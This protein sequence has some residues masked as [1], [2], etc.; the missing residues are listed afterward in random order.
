MH[1]HKSG[2][3]RQHENK[4]AAG[5]EPVPKSLASA[6]LFIDHSATSHVDVYLGPRAKA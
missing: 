3:A 6:L 5:T 1:A 2:G 4:A